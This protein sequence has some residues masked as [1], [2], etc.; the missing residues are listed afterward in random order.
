MSLLDF[1]IHSIRK[2]DMSILNFTN[3]L[4]PCDFASKIELP[5]LLTKI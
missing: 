3:D 5:F 4:V 1:M 2:N